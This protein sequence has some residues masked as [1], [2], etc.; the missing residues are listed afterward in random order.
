MEVGSDGGDGSISSD[1]SID[2]GG[3]SNDFGVG[4]DTGDG[5]QRGESCGDV[6]DGTG[7][8]SSDGG[9]GVGDCAGDVGIGKVCREESEPG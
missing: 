4:D 8:K 3:V 2:G 9:E 6:N 5:R 1:C 7:F